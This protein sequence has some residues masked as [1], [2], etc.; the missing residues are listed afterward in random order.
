MSDNVKEPVIIT[1]TE[2]SR[3]FSDLLH[4]VCYGG[5]S[6]II[7]KGQRLMAR[8][9]PVVVAEEEA[10][11]ITEAVIAPGASYKE[12]DF[13]KPLPA[14]LLQQVVVQDEPTVDEAEYY[15]TV[16]DQLRKTTF[17]PCDQ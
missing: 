15:K 17:E 10:E 9:V 3:S 6:F 8:V 5:E 4:R 14:E 2:A 7:K 16:L 11:P 13:S 12:S 1:A